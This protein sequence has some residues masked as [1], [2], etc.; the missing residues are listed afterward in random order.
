MSNTHR[1]IPYRVRVGVTIST[2]D[3]GDIQRE[4]KTLE[5]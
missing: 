1:F 2:V 4:K 5:Y 3:E